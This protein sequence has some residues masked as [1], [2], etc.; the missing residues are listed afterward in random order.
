MSNIF[1]REKKD[2]NHRMILNLKP[3]N[4][5]VKYRHFKMDSLSSV[6]KLVSKDIW[7]SSVDLIQAYYTCPVAKE[8]QK[9]LKFYWK[10]V[11]YKYTCFPNGL[12][13]CP[14]KFTKLLKP[15]FSKLRLQGHVV[16][17]YIDDTFLA[18]DSEPDCWD[19]VKDTVALLQKL[20]FV[21]HPDKS[22]FKPQKTLT[23]LGFVIDSQNMTVS[24]TREKKTLKLKTLC[25]KIYKKKKVTIR[26]V[27]QLLGNMTVVMF[28]PLY[29][30]TIE[31]EKSDALMK[32]KG[33]Y[34]QKMTLSENA[35]R[36][37]LWW[38]ENIDHSYNMIS[39]DSPNLIM[40]TDT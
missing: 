40:F 39:R 20:G 12:A 24:L 2:G 35:K 34:D 22:S 5:H 11:L 14:R 1:V 7:M 19:N 8:H 18:G 38:I 9:Y 3:L 17:G 16:S 13:F 27:A 36:D 28:A 4:K 10:G 33:N 25:R 23:F 15:V 32:A 37:L 21:I 6:L 30:R 29:Y 31:I 26:K